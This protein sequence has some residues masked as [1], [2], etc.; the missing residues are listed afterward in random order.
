M[1]LLEDPLPIA[2][3]ISCFQRAPQAE[4]PPP[5]DITVT[6]NKVGRRPDRDTRLA[7]VGN[8]SYFSLSVQPA[9]SLPFFSSLSSGSALAICR[10]ESLPALLTKPPQRRISQQNNGTALSLSRRHV[11]GF[12]SPTA[13]DYRLTRGW[14]CIHTIQNIFPAFTKDFTVYRTSGLLVK[15]FTGLNSQDAYVQESLIAG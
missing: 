5:K 1:A 7:P 12:C 4:A 6:H 3:E 9:R 15:T 8:Q 14:I 11:Q 13:D 2:K 10:Q